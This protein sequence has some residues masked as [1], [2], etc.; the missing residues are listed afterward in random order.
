MIDMGRVLVGDDLF[1]R[2]GYGQGDIPMGKSAAILSVDF[3]LGFTSGDLAIGKSEHIQAS[4]SAAARLLSRARN[5]GTPVFHTFV[6]Y[7][8]D[9]TDLGLWRWKVPSL[10]SFTEGSGW[11]HIDSRLLGEGDVVIH[12]RKPSA[13]FGTGLDAMLRESDIDSLVIC[14]VTTSGCVRASIID[15]FSYGFHCTVAADACGDQDPKAHA[16][17]LEDVSRRYANVRSVDDICGELFT[18]EERSS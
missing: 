2:A 17:N 11:D 13:F 12:K 5:C 3:Q 7:R 6:R 8:V 4:V 10:A 9:E 14:G 15:A 18:R 1:F 16:A